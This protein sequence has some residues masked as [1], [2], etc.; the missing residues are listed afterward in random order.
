MAHAHSSHSESSSSK[1]DEKEDK[2]I[3]ALEKKRASKVKEWMGYEWIKQPTATL[4]IQHKG[5][6]DMDGLLKLIAGFYTEHKFKFYEKQQRHR[7]PGPFG[8]ERFY[9]FEAYRNVD[10]YHRFNSFIRLETFDEQ[11]VEVIGRDG[12]K[13]MMAKGRLWIQMGCRVDNDFDERWTKS[14]FSLN[15]RKFFNTRV[16]PKR[17][18][19]RFWDTLYY[20]VLLKLHTLITEKL[21]MESRFNEDRYRAGVH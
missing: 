16:I 8:V 9:V 19:L 21:K 20:T 18:E 2:A 3:A 5:V 6:W 10:E 11:D 17:M 7:H 12:S 4:Y 15:L 13:R 14:W 1:S